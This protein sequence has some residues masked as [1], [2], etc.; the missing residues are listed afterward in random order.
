MCFKHL[1]RGIAKRSTQAV[2]L[3]I[4]M[5]VVPMCHGQ[6]TFAVLGGKVFDPDKR[7]VP[8]ATVVVTSDERGTQW[9]TTTNGAG[10]WRVDDLIAGHY[11]W[12]VN[13]NGFK[14]LSHSSIELRIGDQKFVDV[15]L[16]VGMANE[17]IVVQSATPLIDTTASVSGTVLDT[18]IISELPSSS[19]TPVDMSKLDAA[20]IYPA[21]SGNPHLYNNANLSSNGVRADG[22]ST[23]N[24]TIDGGT[25]VH[26]QAGS[27]YIAFVPPSDSVGEMRIVT[28]AFDASIGRELGTSI[29][30]SMKS[31]TS[32]YHGTLYEINQNA[33]LN[34]RPYASAPTTPLPP[35]H[36]NE[37]G[38]TVG[39]PIMIPK[40]YDGKKHNSFFFFSLDQ[41]RNESPNTV[42]GKTMSLPTALERQGDFSQSFTTASVGGKLTQYPIQIYDPLTW[43][44]KTGQRSLISNNGTT[45]PSDRISAVAKAYFALMPLP[46][47]PNDAAGDTSNNYLKTSDRDQNSMT[48]LS[49]RLDQAESNNHHTFGEFRWSKWTDDNYDPFG[50]GEAA[51]LS[52]VMETRENYG[53]TI[54]HAWTLSPKLL[55][56]LNANLTAYRDTTSSQA[57]GVDP[58]TFGFSDAL[59]AV[60]QVKGLP[61]ITG[62]GSGW[63][64]SG[65]GMNQAPNYANNLLWEFYPTFTQV[66]GNHTIRYG[67]NYTLQQ[68][69][70]GSLTNGEVTFGFGTNWTTKN[71]NATAGTGEGSDTASFLLG[72]PTTGSQVQ[73][74]T[75]FWSLP[76]F[77]AFSQDDWRVTPKLTLNLGLRW[78]VQSGI[79]ER[80]NRFWSRFDPDE[81]L[82]D[83]TNFIQ[84]KYAALVASPGANLGLQ[85]LAQYGSAPSDFKALGAVHYAGVDGTPR[86]VEDNKYTYF[87]PRLGFAYQLHNNMVLKGGFGRF[88]GPPLFD[89]YRASQT[90]FSAS[91]TFQPTLDTFHTINA[92]MDNPF[93]NGLTPIVGSGNGIYTN[94]GGITSYYD[95]AGGPTYT[96]E[97]AL[98]LQHQLGSWLLDY[99]ATLDL[100]GGIY[101]TYNLDN[102]PPAA[103]VAEYKPRFDA[104]GRPLDTL[105]GDQPVAN[106]FLGAPYITNGLQNDTTI[107]VNT[108]IH[109]NP[110]GCCSVT[111]P[112]GRSD[113]YGTQLKAERRFKHGLG[114]VSNF[115]WTKKMDKTAYYTN[116]IFSTQ[117]RRTLSPDDIRFHIVVSPTYVLPF[118]RGE[119][120]GSHVNRYV[121]N[122]I[123]GWEVSGIYI[124]SSGAPVSFPTNSSYWDGKDPALKSGKSRAKWFDTSHFY[125]FPT[126]SYSTATIASYPAWT[127][128]EGLPGASWQPTSSTDATRNGVYN[129][130]RLW[131]TNNSPY[132]GDVRNPFS[133][134]VDLGVRKTFS[135]YRE[136]KFQL[137]FDAFN[138]L[139]HPLITG[140]NTTPGNAYFGRLSGTIK[141]AASNQSRAI[142]LGGKIIF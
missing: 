2:S 137:R 50:Q 26:S 128:V 16:A 100:A 38:G 133:N 11:H 36:F 61:L 119:L 40:V 113:F 112:N 98:H 105:P 109:T 114:M 32:Q 121:D 130:Y 139:N 136:A 141:Y 94:A 84:P 65:M 57:V 59:A 46:N 86:T 48:T 99:G 27:N 56:E 124:F 93:P 71:P 104:T 83:I 75:A 123:S 14:T 126:K 55:L 3:L 110:L 102:M 9:T 58:T 73:N 18:K 45:I 91:T 21:S 120:I 4:L 138:A 80:F 8:N 49:F 34:A 108:L 88:V 87:Q 29:Q 42:S 142:Q 51:V 92:T 85:V 63:D 78:M 122:L 68:D 44:S 15:T 82:P 90:G 116:H 107:S 53:V 30:M 81:N 70:E 89:V 72:L 54:G 25:D 79:T 35:V 118:G 76:S 101:I 64:K 115:S 117:L 135:L 140:P 131:N 7:V 1:A 12:E 22:L 24:F 66:L 37:Y 69:A 106:P 103:F 62:V 52:D 5:A 19:N 6:E 134:N 23:L 127:G 17:T 28:N 20:V 111:K 125:P 95:P 39:G 129:D 10:S 31:G 33:F 60:Q 13:S 43:N 47:Q 77:S 97:A 74:A 132:F 67:V 41:L 96:Y